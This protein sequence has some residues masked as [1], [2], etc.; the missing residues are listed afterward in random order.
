LPVILYNNPEIHGNT[1]LPLPFIEESIKSP[2]VIGIKDTSRDAEY[3]AQLL[4]LREDAVGK[5]NLGILQGSTGYLLSSLQQ[6]ADGFIC[7][8]GNADPKLLADLYMSFQDGKMQKA[9]AIMDEIMEMRKTLSTITGIKSELVKKGI[10]SSS[11][12]LGK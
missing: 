8:M 2:R 3:F 9:Q 4:K 10:I 1:K 11:R 12:I 5:M 6:G 7:V